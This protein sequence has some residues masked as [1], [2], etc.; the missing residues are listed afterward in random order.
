MAGWIVGMNDLLCAMS[1]HNYNGFRI[2]FRLL[3]R[4]R[5]GADRQPIAHAAEEDSEIHIVGRNLDVTSAED[6]KEH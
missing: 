3:K 1:G 2:Q 5:N 4:E 6:N